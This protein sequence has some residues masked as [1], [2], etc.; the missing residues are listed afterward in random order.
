MVKNIIG[1]R[2]VKMIVVFSEKE[3]IS[4]LLFWDG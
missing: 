2:K 4:N 3:E 1:R